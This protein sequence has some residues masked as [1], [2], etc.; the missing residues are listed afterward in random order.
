MLRWRCLIHPRADIHY[1]FRCRIAAGA[2][3][4]KSTLVCRGRLPFAI[5]VGRSRIHDGVILDSLYGHI[6]IGDATSLNPYC[7]LYGTGG[8]S[9]GSSC[10]IA[11][12][13][14]VI[15]AEHSFAN[16]DIPIMQQP[17]QSKG[18]SIEDDVWVGAGSR[19]LDGVRLRS[20]T[21]VGAGA[22]VTR[23]FP[24]RSVI[25]GVPARLLSIRPKNTQ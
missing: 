22:V 5:T 8:L 13:T 14:V 3:I 19:I 17:I 7:V 9:I 2:R 25:V 10:G 21:V 4:G 1:P 23:D 6:D 24:P 20:G 11:A 12:Q 15:A 16:P 18:I